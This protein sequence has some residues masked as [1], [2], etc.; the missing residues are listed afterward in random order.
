MPR[1]ARPVDVV[2]RIGIDSQLTRRVVRRFLGDLHAMQARTPAAQRLKARDVGELG[3][4]VFPGKWHDKK[5][6]ERVGECTGWVL[7][8][9][10]ETM[11][12][13]I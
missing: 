3:R 7:H 8:A 2:A 6:A 5:A 11:F 9:S 13:V 4:K 10:D 1:F 12:K